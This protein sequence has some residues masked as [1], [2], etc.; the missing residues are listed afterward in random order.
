MDFWPETTA[1]KTQVG[2]ALDFIQSAQ[3]GCRLAALTSGFTLKSW[4]SVAA[5]VVVH[6]YLESLVCF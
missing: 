2:V 5:A 4:L 3:P 1:P 6:F